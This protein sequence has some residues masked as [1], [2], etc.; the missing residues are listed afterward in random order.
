M[1]VWGEC[2][3][4]RCLSDGEGGLGRRCNVFAWEGVKGVFC[5]VIGRWEAFL[6]VDPR[7]PMSSALG[8]LSGVS[9]SKW[10]VGDRQCESFEFFSWYAGV[11]EYHGGVDVGA[12]DFVCRVFGH[13][14]RRGVVTVRILGVFPFDGVGP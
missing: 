8:G 13:S 2:V 14:K 10:Y 3:G 11:G 5:E 1:V 7:A 12:F 4:D 9:R 6:G